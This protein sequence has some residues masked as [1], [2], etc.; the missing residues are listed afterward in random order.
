MNYLI[1][2]LP[3]GEWNQ[4]VTSV[5]IISAHGLHAKETLP[6]SD[7]FKRHYATFLKGGSWPVSLYYKSWSITNKQK[8]QGLFKTTPLIVTPGF[9]RKTRLAVVKELNKTY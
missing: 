9:S 2:P 8:R 3:T 5:P 7:P 4:S 6:P 1:I